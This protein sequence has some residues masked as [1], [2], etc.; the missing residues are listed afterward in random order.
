METEF[1]KSINEYP[2]LFYLLRSRES[3]GLIFQSDKDLII[4]LKWNYYIKENKIRLF[5]H[6]FIINYV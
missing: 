5:P 4:P 6:L 1:L 3:N 2:E